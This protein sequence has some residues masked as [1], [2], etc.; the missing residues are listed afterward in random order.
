[1]RTLNGRL[2]CGAEVSLQ[3]AEQYCAAMARREAKNFYWGFILTAPRY[4]LRAA[5]V[6]RAACVDPE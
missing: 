4:A 6:V 5:A 1:M 3:A 2:E